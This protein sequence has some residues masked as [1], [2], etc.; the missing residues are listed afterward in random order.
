[1]Y[2]DDATFKMMAEKGVYWVPTLMAYLQGMDGP[3]SKMT[4]EQRR[5]M[6]GT[7]DRHRETFQR[8]LK[9]P[10]KIAFGTD[11]SGNH[12][13]AAQEFIWMARY[14][15]PPLEV[16]RSATSTAAELMGWQ[17]RIGTLEPGKLADVVA[18][19]GNP[20]E[21]Y[22]RNEAHRVRHEGWCDIPLGSG[23]TTTWREPPVSA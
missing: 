2:L 14:G 21:R 3:E 13:N 6:T 23:C 20:V 17:D 10:V 16:L 12:E 1:M 8:A 7:T 5:I 9:T 11:L 18:V 4:P 22:H 19:E 15:M